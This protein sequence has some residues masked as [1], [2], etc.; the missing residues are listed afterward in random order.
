ME[1]NVSVS[2]TNCQTDLLVLQN[3]LPVYTGGPNVEGFLRIL[4]NLMDRCNVGETDK[5]VLLLGQIK[6]AAAQWLQI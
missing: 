5:Y 2:G 3:S 6:G 1:G 4:E